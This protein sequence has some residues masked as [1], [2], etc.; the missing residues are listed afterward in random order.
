[1]AERRTLEF[2]SIDQVMP[3]V[4]RLLESYA[5]AGNW[6]LGQV[7]S[8]LS[9]T[10]RYSLEGFNVK[11]PWLVRTLFG[12]SAKKKVLGS[13]QMPAGIKLPERFLPKPELDDRAEAE[14]LRASVA[15]FNAHSGPVADH[16]MFGPMTRA[17]WDRLHCIH[18]AHHL[19]FLRPGRA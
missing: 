18:C 2:T 19:S 8:H 4:D 17:E 15:L 6:S 9:H 10:F 3:E 1:M 13:G 5:P 16:P 11:A 7:C 12:R 14:A